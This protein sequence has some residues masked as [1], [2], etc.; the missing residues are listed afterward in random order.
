MR[1]SCCLSN[2]F[3]TVTTNVNLLI[4]IVLLGTFVECTTKIYA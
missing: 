3:S 1:C 2:E 4:H